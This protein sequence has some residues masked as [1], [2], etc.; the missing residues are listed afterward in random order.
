MRWSAEAGPS[1]Y[2]ILFESS[3]VSL[4]LTVFP[5]ST[6]IGSGVGGLLAYIPRQEPVGGD[7]CASHFPEGVVGGAH[8]GW[9]CL[10]VFERRG[11]GLRFDRL[12]IYRRLALEIC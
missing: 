12:Y 3:N 7:D 9:N 1:V 10:D 4:I 2:G 11:P 6:L 5:G 8:V